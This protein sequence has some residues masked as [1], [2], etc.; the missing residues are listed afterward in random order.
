MKETIK[1]I[2]IIINLWTNLQKDYNDIDNLLYMQQ[3]LSGYSYT[4]A[5]DCAE[6]KKDYN[7]AYFWRKINL[8]KHK[9]T[10][11][12]LG[13]SA[14]SAESMAIERT[15]EELR[16]EIET[17]ATA[18]KAEMILKQINQILGSLTQRV[19]YLKKESENT[20]YENNLK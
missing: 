14:T 2:G 8:N 12:G 19:S 17:E 20:R 3:K 4:L 10:Y 11:I 1:E 18:F 13:H 6:F 5:C 15:E 16:K 9:N 7:F